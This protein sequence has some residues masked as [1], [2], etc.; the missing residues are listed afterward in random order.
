MNQYGGL[1]IAFASRGVG[2]ALAHYEPVAKIINLTN[3]RGDGSLCHEW[4]HYLDNIL[5]SMNGKNESIAMASEQNVKLT[6]TMGRVSNFAKNYWVQLS[7]ADIMSYIQDSDYY[8]Q[9]SKMSSDYW[10]KP[11]EL[12]ARAFETYVFDKLKKA[13]RENNYLVSDNYFAAINLRSGDIVY[14]YPQSKERE[15]LFELFDKLFATIKEQYQIDGFKAFTK[16]RKDETIELPKESSN[17]PEPTFVKQLLG[18]K[19]LLE[20]V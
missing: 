3:R 16:K 6:R 17:E 1:S 7:I 20:A 11:V 15:V 18:F 9:S 5:T 13:D 14:V 2:K 12:F 10:I 19:R 4:G 8:E